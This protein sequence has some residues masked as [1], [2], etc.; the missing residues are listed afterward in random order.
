MWASCSSC[1][2][3]GRRRSLQTINE[4]ISLHI[5]RSQ[6]PWLF[7]NELVSLT[8]VCAGSWGPLELP[9]ASFPPSLG[10]LSC[11]ERGSQ[12]ATI[13]HWLWGWH[14]GC[15]DCWLPRDPASDDEGGQRPLCIRGVGYQ[16][17]FLGT[18]CKWSG[19][20][21]IAAVKPQAPDLLPV[22][23]E[24]FLKSLEEKNLFSISHQDEWAEQ[25]IFYSHDSWL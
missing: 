5:L 16:E 18:I 17:C 4:M 24:A 15:A 9:A 21:L 1:G 14:K 22:S 12:A 13:H 25:Q 20:G 6:E 3:S 8:A 19:P 10:P 7:T 23:F 11:W 2:R